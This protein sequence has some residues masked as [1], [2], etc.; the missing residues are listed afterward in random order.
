M[1]DGQLPAPPPPAQAAQTRLPWWRIARASI[2]LI[3]EF[4]QMS[5]GAGDILD[6]LI[7]STIIEGNLAVVNQDAELQ[8]AY[9]E[10]DSAPPDE[11][12]RP[13]SIAAVAGSLNVPYETVRRRVARLA[14]SGAIVQT[15]KGL[16]VPSSALSHPMYVITAVARYERM[17]RFYFELKEMGV[18]ENLPAPD[19]A[20]PPLRAPPVR[21]VN[22]LIGEYMLRIIEVF[23]A[24]LGDAVTGLVAMEMG[25]A[26]A[27]H[28]DEAAR[29]V[30]GPMPDDL[31]KPIAMLAL[32]KRLRLPPETVRRHVNRLEELGLCHK[33]PGGRLAEIR[34]LQG[35]GEGHSPIGWNLMNM[36]R[37]M[38]RLSAFGV[39]TYWDAERE[40]VVTSPAGPG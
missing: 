35:T 25:R 8:R 40:G 13:V 26:N 28:L 18:L 9:A 16:V 6:P 33:V 37:L 12:R 17:K 15:S 23:M 30:E 22:R 5:R 38:A 7:V 11:M 21:L 10:L 14:N 24:R 27:E 1:D 36:M 3:L 4:I 20:A 34:E 19:S 31:R 2:S 39:L 29:Q 32:A